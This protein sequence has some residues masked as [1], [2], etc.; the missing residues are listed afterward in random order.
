MT[1]ETKN[2]YVEMPEDVLKTH[3]EQI[4]SVIGTKKID[5]TQ[6]FGE[7]ITQEQKDKIAKS[8]ELANKVKELSDKASK[9]NL[10][11]NEAKLAQASVDRIVND[12]RKIDKDAPLDKVLDSKFNNLQ[13]LDILA[14]TQDVIQHYTSQMETLRQEIGSQGQPNLQTFGKPATNDSAADIIKSM[15]PEEK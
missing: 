11:D 2:P 15:L 5:V 9:E 13:K 1:E 3:L 6:F 7:P 12:I 4:K 10:T 14:G 8:D